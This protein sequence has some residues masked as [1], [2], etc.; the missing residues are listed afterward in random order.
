MRTPTRVPGLALN[1]DIANPARATVRFPSQLPDNA[2]CRKLSALPSSTQ[3]LGA[4]VDLLA[5][6]NLGQT[7]AHAAVMRGSYDVLKSLADRGAPLTTPDRFGR[8]PFHLAC[9]HQWH[10]VS[11]KRC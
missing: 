6:N 7:A 10:S 5:T 2:F 1:A 3:L 4:H 9:M 11:R 8:T